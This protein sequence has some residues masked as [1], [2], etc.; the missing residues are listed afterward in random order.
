MFFKR[1]FGQGSIF[2]LRSLGK[3][4]F[5]SPGLGQAQLLKVS[6]FICLQI[7]S[8]YFFVAAPDLWM[9]MFFIFKIVTRVLL[10]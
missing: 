7:M 1:T 5:S 2:N 9:S 8:S 4:I 10:R 6:H 3:E